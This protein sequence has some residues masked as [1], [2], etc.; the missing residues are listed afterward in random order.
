[1][2]ERR[3]RFDP[4]TLA[5]AGADPDPAWERN[6]K[7]WMA[8]YKALVIFLRDVRSQL[9]LKAGEKCPKCGHTF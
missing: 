3:P 5:A 6:R 7:L 8:L 1:M 9:D 4:H 2:S